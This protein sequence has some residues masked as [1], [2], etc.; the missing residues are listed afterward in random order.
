MSGY[1][2]VRIEFHKL[3]TDIPVRY[4]FLSKSIE[5]GTDQVFEGTTAKLGGSG[6]LMN[7]KIPRLNWVPA[8]LM[9]KVLLG[10]NL[11]LP[12]S[13]EPIKALCKVAWIEAMTEDSDRVVMG[14]QFMDISKES[15]D[16]ITRY[17]IR[18]QIT[19]R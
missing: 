15:Q 8:I 12:S 16:Q 10:V 6:C 5:L 9:G 11:L 18:S 1:E 17:L 4:K 7:G 19:T 14:L 13:D 2:S 3:H